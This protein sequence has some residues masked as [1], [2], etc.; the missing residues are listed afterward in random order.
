[1][2]RVAGGATGRGRPLGT[3]PPGGDAALWH[4][5]ECGA[6]TADLPIWRSLAAEAP[7]PVLDLGCGTGRVAL[8]LAERGHDVT[9]LDCDPDLLRTLTRRARARDLRVRTHTGDARAFELGATWAL[10]IAAMQVVQLLGGPDG[11]RRMLEC[12]RRHLVPGGLLAAAIADPFEGE[13]AAELLPPLPDMREDDGWVYSSTP[14]ALRSERGGATAIDRLRQAVSPAGEVTEVVTTVV[15]DPVSAGDLE[16]AAA[17]VG[18]TPLP[19]RPV[20]ATDAHVESTVVILRA[21]A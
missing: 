2:V 3:R 14:V 1:M 20:P 16:A 18:F 12:A 5:V 9:A 7:G 19:P 4:D 10:A 6:Y 17:S 13:A 11:R 8:D 15:L 21:E